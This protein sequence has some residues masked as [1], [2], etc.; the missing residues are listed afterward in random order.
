MKFSRAS[1]LHANGDKSSLYIVGVDAHTKRK[2]LDKLG[3]TEVTMPFRGLEF[4]LA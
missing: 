4:P 1:G 3:Y 2:L